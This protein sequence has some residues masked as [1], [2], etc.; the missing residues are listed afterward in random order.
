VSD[1][2][3]LVVAVTGDNLIKALRALLTDLTASYAVAGQARD[4][5]S[6][7][8]LIK[9]V[10]LDLEAALTEAVPDV[11]GTALDELT[12]RRKAA[13]RPDAAAIAAAQVGP[14]RR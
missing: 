9:D 11:K 14:K 13:G 4:K 2:D 12:A 6:L 1:P 8:R 10:R 3:Q 7:G 5:A